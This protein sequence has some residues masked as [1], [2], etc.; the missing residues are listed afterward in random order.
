MRGGT[1]GLHITALLVLQS[2][3]ESSSD[4]EKASSLLKYMNKKRSHFKLKD[5]IAQINRA[6]LIPQLSKSIRKYFDF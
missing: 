6:A 2:K 1:P 5:L 3:P 4:I